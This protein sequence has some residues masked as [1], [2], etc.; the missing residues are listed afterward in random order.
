MMGGHDFSWLSE[1][2]AMDIGRFDASC[3][4]PQMFFS[5]QQEL[6]L[7]SNMS[8]VEVTLGQ[9][10]IALIARAE[11]LIDQTSGA[12]RDQEI[13][14]YP[15]TIQANDLVNLAPSFR[16]NDVVETGGLVSDLAVSRIIGDDRLVLV[17]RVGS[18]LKIIYISLIERDWISY[19]LE[20]NTE[21]VYDLKVKLGSRIHISARV[22][23]RIKLWRIHPQTGAQ[24]RELIIGTQVNHLKTALNGDQ[25]GILYQEGM[26]WEWC[27]VSM[28]SYNECMELPS[29]PFITESDLAS[30]INLVEAKIDPRTWLIALAGGGMLRGVTIDQN[31]VLLNT[32]TMTLSEPYLA[33][34]PEL[35][36]ERLVGGGFLASTSGQDTPL[37][38]FTMVPNVYPIGYL[39]QWD[40]GANLDIGRSNAMLSDGNTSRWSAMGALDRTLGQYRIRI[41]ELRCQ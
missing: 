33:A 34:E 37:Q 19:D 35:K 20:L 21:Q 4:E 23:N 8:H 9:G 6:L 31:A 24:E 27:V 38:V 36:L 15:G 2:P 28:V 14:V 7:E 26:T 13:V 5:D 17:A 10:S 16:V 25:L 1:P 22:N 32:G 40:F 39:G 11:P 3:P 12:V 41:A 29:L 18:V 30:G